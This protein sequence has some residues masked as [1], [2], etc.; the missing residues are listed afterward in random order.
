MNQ[1]IRIAGNF[2]P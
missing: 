1:N 2:K